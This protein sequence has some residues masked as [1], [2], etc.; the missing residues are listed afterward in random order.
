MPYFLLAKLAL[1]PGGVGLGVLDSFVLDTPMVTTDVSYQGPEIEY[2][3]DGVNGL[4]VAGDPG[5][6]EYASAV[7][8]T[9]RDDALLARLR[10][11]CRERRELYTIEAMVE[12][13]AAGVRAAL[14]AS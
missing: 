13:F 11:G 1:M 7:V 12:N 9:L 4:V 10:Q 3:L 14:A 2:L 8:S 5:P 6:R